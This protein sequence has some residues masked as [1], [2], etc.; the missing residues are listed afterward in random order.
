MVFTIFVAVPSF[1]ISGFGILAIVDARAVA[2]ARLKQSY[3]QKLRLLAAELAAPLEPVAR[4]IRDAPGDP[5]NMNR[6]VEAQLG[7]VRELLPEL[8]P[9]HFPPETAVVELVHDTDLPPANT[10]EAMR[11]TLDDWLQ[12]RAEPADLFRR[13]VITE[14]RLPPPLDSYR[15]QARLLGDDLLAQQVR[16]TAVLYSALLFLFYVLLAV[17]VAWVSMSLY[18]EVQLGRLKTDFVS[19]VSH[20]LRTPLTSIRMFLET[21]R[22]GRV[23]SREEEL[24]CLRLCAQE[25]E[26]LSGMI[27]RVLDWARVEAGKKSYQK[28]PVTAGEIAE[29]ALQSFATQALEAPYVLTR[30]VLAPD[31]PLLVDPDAIT[32]ALLNLLHNAFK[33]T[34]E[35]KR[36]GLRVEQRG[37]MVAFAVSDNGPGVPRR[38]QKKIFERFYRAEDP[39]N[40]RAHG[41][42]LGLALARH[43]VEAH[44]G[45]I[46]LQSTPG[47]GSTFTVELPTASLRQHEQALMAEARARG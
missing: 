5:E 14:L 26:R 41:S 15:L 2:E 43:V 10:A 44:G 31:A 12:G 22:L 38:E 11:R 40:A 46:R 42:G 33:Y 19:H 23:Q 37:S 34:A 30:E 21:V 32:E 18:R 28:R 8:A 39:L 45:R 25:T 6:V 16:T 1:A 24:E 27:E 4:A 7:R 36:I 47:K 35:E 3:A 17:G 13:D 29:A 20:E 9:R